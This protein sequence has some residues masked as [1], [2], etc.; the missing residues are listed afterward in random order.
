MDIAGIICLEIIIL[1]I[2]IEFNNVQRLSKRHR[3]MELSR[4]ELKRARNGDHREP[5]KI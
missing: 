2:G 1:E 3:E 5:V 4:V